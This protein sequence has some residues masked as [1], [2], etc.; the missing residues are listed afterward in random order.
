MKA[1]LLVLAAILVSGC[2]SGPDAADKAPSGPGLIAGTSSGSHYLRFDK[3]HYEQSLSENK[4]VHL[5]FYANWCPICA[6]ER[7]K[8]FEAYG[9]LNYEDV[10]GYEVHYNDNEVTDDDVYVTKLFQIP[11]QHTTVILDRSGKIA[12][13]SFSP[14]GTG[15]LVEEIENARVP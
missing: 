15:K 3:A 8:I 7:P 2:T 14:I 1:V 5:Y 4:V 11:Y 6:A 13:K 10:V 9:K 12:F